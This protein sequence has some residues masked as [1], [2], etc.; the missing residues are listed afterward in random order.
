MAGLGA[1]VK[2]CF[3][4]RARDSLK[5]SE[6]RI[7]LFVSQASE[8]GYL[9]QNGQNIFNIQ[10]WLIFFLIDHINISGCCQGD[11]TI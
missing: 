5:L 9:V 8:D 10:K 3:T 6:E 7:K 1:L 2:Y 4:S 11:L